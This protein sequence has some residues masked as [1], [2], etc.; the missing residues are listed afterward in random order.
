MEALVLAEPVTIHF[1][2]GSGILYF[3]DSAAGTS[4]RTACCFSA[5][6]FRCESDSAVYYWK[7]YSDSVYFA[8]YQTDI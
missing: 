6:D 4:R 7:Y 2:G 3:H 1:T 8:V 5:E